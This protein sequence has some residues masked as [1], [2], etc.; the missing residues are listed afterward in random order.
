M[1]KETK[2]SIYASAIANLTARYEDAMESVQHHAAFNEWDHVR[3][4][5]TELA[6]LAAS[7]RDATK[8]KADI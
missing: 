6:N 1:T 8:R 2:Q 3:M 7:L 4:L 5:H